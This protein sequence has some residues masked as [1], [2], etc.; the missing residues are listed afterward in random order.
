MQK[1]R[2]MI[3]SVLLIFIVST[4]LISMTLGTFTMSPAEVFQTFFGLGSS[5][6]ELVLF[7][8]RLPRM[9]L[10]ILVGA[11]LAVSGAI[12]QAL[13]RNDLAD[14]GI[15]GINAGAGLAIVLF[16]YFFQGSYAD[17]GWSI[18]MLP[19]FA[20]LGAL[21]AAF[22]IYTIAWKQGV[23]PVRLVLVGIGI[24]AGLWRCSLCSNYAIQTTLCQATIWL[25]GNIWGSSWTYVLAIFPWLFVLMLLV[26][27][28]ANTLNVMRLGDASS[29]SLGVRVEPVRRR[30]LVFA[31]GL[32]GASVAAG[33]AISF[34]GLVAPHI[35]RRLVGPRHGVMIPVA[36]LVGAFFLL[37][38]D[39][40]ARNVLSPSEIPVGIIVAMIGAPYFL[41]L[42]MK[43]A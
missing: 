20:F 17:L 1:R 7:Q 13:S 34:I 35:A 42:L 23:T 24:N 21:V 22:L 27:R 32:A 30:L 37:F 25:T 18:Y 33:G 12:L 38:S 4:F 26:L 8:F 14:P 43:T 39:M 29:V 10:A 3:I 16:I 9:V 2:T 19:L 11:G 36:A 5:Q 40:I 28:D 41:Y 6:Q 15:L 31:V